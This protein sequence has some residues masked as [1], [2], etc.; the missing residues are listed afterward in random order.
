MTDGVTFMKS[1]FKYLI[2]KNAEFPASLVLIL[3][4][5]DFD[6]NFLRKVGFDQAELDN[7][8]EYKDHPNE[9]DSLVYQF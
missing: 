1:F 3:P 8:R 5:V 6:K 7:D 4:R 2:I 9:S